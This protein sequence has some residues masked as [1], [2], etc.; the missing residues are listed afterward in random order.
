MERK[1]EWGT[2]LLRCQVMVGGMLS[3]LLILHIRKLRF[4]SWLHL[5]SSFQEIELVIQKAKDHLHAKR[6]KLR[7]FNA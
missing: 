6:C 7:A 3:L 5:L 2:F 1:V 4:P